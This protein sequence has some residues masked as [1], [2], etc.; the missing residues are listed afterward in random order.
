MGHF[1]SLAMKRACSLSPQELMT[2]FYPSV[3][4]EQDRL[5]LMGVQNGHQM[6]SAPSALENTQN[7]ESLRF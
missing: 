5:G 2:F 4:L 3:A 6:T 1:F 7:G